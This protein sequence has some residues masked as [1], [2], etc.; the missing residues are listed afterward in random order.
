MSMEFDPGHELSHF[1]DAGHELYG[2]PLRVYFYL[3][4]TCHA[5]EA[6]SEPSFS[7]KP[8]S[9]GCFV[10]FIIRKAFWIERD[11]RSSKAMGGFG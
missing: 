8:A 3:V 11:A 6:F 5:I 9:A 2:L 4:E 10:E 1:G 7:I